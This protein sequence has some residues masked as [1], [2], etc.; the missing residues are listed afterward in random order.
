MTKF[1]VQHV[2]WLYVV[3]VL[4][5]FTKRAL[6][7]SLGLRPT[8]DL[9]LDALNTAVA[10]ACPAGSRSYELNLMSDNGSQPTSKKYETALVTLGIQHVTTSFNNP[11]G[12][13]DTER[14]M[15]TFK[16]EAV[17]P[18]EYETLVEAQ[19]TVQT[20]F[21]FYNRDY[22]HSTLGGMIPRDFE[23]CLPD[24][25][26]TLNQGEHPITQAARHSTM[27]TLNS[28]S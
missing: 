1:Y 6:G 15:R 2:G 4:D 16:E 21:E 11:K 3:V 8:T 22:P 25:Q 19:R 14:F 17:W 12:N 13:A 24:R 28:F 23:A 10:T 20:F 18:W 27:K 26:A 9:W 5:W 7:H